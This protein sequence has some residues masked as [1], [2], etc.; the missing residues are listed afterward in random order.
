MSDYIE[1]QKM[2]TTNKTAVNFLQ[3]AW[4]PTGKQVSPSA[5][6][7]LLKTHL[8]MA[9]APGNYHLSIFMDVQ[10]GH[11]VSGKKQ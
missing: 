2:R 4:Q 8:N 5:V 11:V 9:S 10:N 6:S 7:P 1:L 3:C